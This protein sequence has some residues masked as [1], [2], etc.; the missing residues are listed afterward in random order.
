M[1][2]CTPCADAHLITLRPSCR[3]F[4]LRMDAGLGGDG[5]EGGWEMEDLELPADLGLDT[6]ATAAA[7]AGAPFV[8][9]TPGEFL[10]G[11]LFER[12]LL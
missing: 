10:V 5:S 9:P 6:A 11:R 1:Y 12:M 4:Y 8:A 7:A 2:R 3:L